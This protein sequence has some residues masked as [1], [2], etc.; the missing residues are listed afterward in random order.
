M[1]MEGRSVSLPKAPCRF[2][3]FQLSLRVLRL[4]VMADHLVDDEPQELFGKLRIELCF[5]RQCPQ[6]GDLTR[7]AT[8]VSRGQG[9]FRL[10]RADGLR[11][12]KSL[13]KHVDQRCID[14]V[15]RSP[16]RRQNRIFGLR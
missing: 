16:V 14:I 9:G 13:G 1:R 11:D 6:S 5:F 12:A 2:L 15:D 4:F 7:L 3:H 8:R 10:V